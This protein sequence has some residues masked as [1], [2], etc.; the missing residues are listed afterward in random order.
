M[1]ITENEV[2]DG[3]SKEADGVVVAVEKQICDLTLIAMNSVV[4]PRVEIAVG[5]ITGFV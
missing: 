2:V 1:K 3:V 4:T 5:S